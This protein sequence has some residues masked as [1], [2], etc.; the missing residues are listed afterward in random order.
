MNNKKIRILI[1][2]FFLL[3]ALSSPVYAASSSNQTKVGYTTS[4][5]ATI[6]SG[7]QTT[8]SGTPTTGDDI[9]IMKYIIA[10]GIS[11]SAITCIILLKRKEDKERKRG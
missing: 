6:P 4:T 10:V 11:I 1:F 3:I 2:A 5:I 9:Y 7:T 8:P